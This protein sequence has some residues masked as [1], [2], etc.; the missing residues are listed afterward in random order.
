MRTMRLRHIETVSF[1]YSEETMY[2][3][4][5]KEYAHLAT[6]GKNDV[7]LFRSVTGNQLVFVFGFSLLNT[8][9]KVECY[10][11]S[12]RLRLPKGREWDPLMLANYAQ[13]CGINLAGI[14]TFKEHL[15]TWRGDISLSRAKAKKK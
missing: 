9:S 1:N 10:L 4:V 5:I 11:R 6:L 2:A 3:M 14:K 13:D 8:A 12:E 15:M 7:V